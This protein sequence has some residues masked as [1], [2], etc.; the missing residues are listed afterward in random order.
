MEKIRVSV[1]CNSN[2]AADNNPMLI[3]VC[4]EIN[5]IAGRDIVSWPRVDE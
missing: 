3:S 4:L 5:S 2:A 1:T